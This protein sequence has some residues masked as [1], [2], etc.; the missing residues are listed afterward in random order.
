MERKDISLRTA[1]KMPCSVTTQRTSRVELGEG[2]VRQVLVEWVPVEVLLDTGSAWTLVRKNWCRRMVGVWCAHGEVVHY[3]IAELEVVVEDK[4]II[5]KA[6][7]SDL[8]PV[9][10]LLGRYVP[11]LFSLI[12]TSDSVEPDS[13]SQ[14]LLPSRL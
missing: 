1:V 7:V 10:L 13:R 12:G 3:S 5:M 6:G 4:K 8:L 2:V 11:E 9:Q 14:V